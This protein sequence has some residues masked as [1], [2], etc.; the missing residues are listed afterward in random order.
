MKSI[1]AEAFNVPNHD[2]GDAQQQHLVIDSRAAA[3]SISQIDFGAAPL[4][5]ASREVL[6]S[7]QFQPG[8]ARDVRGVQPTKD[9]VVPVRQAC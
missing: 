2:L 3:Y 1:R 7:P 5:F 8:L 6:S 4:G 9:I